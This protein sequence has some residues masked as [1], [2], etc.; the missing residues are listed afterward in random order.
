MTIQPRKQNKIHLIYVGKINLSHNCYRRSIQDSIFIPYS[1]LEGFL[2]ENTIALEREGYS[3]ARLKT[4]NITKKGN[5]IFTQLLNST[6]KTKAT[7]RHC[8]KTDRR[9]AKKSTFPPDI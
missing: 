2:K 7:K 5:T 8:N 6:Q 3:L 1:K 4:K 9:P